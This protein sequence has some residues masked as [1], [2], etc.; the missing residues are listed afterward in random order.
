M[1]APEPTA[2]D[3]RAAEEYQKRVC[4][5]LLGRA[6]LF[7]DSYL[8]GVLAERQRAAAIVQAAID[9]DC[10]AAPESFCECYG[11]Q[12]LSRLADLILAG[13]AR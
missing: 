9:C 8:A 7:D 1:P 10:A 12:T 11:W 6:I 3:I 13:P 4:D 2:A 5:G